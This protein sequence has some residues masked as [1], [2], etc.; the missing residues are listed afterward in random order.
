MKYDD[1]NSTCKDILKAGVYKAYIE[2]GREINFSPDS[3]NYLLAKKVYVDQAIKVLKEENFEVTT[4]R[5]D[6]GNLEI[7]IRFEVN[8]VANNLPLRKFLTF[9]HVHIP[10]LLIKNSS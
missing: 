3:P 10:T 8:G 7:I 2:E 6:E 5:N 4:T 9:H 1:L